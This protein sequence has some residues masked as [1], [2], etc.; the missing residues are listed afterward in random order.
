MIL[1][2]RYF[3]YFGPES[4]CELTLH[5]TPLY[6]VFFTELIEI[7]SHCDQIAYICTLPLYNC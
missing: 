1:Q 5:V 6:Y 3:S 2:Q 7:L 4:T